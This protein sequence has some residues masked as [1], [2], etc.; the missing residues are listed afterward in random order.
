MTDQPIPLSKLN[1]HHCK[2]WHKECSGLQYKDLAKTGD[3]YCINIFK[4]FAEESVDSVESKW[5]DKC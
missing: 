3:T 5:M 2:L 1:C 4:N